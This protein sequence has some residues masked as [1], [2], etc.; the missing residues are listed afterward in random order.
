VMAIGGVAA[1]AYAFT[2]DTVGWQI[3]IFAVVS[4]GGTVLARPTLIRMFESKT[5]TPLLPGVQQLVGQTAIATGDV[6]D[7]HHAGHVRIGGESWLAVCDGDAAI[8]AETEVVI[9]AVRGT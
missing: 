9:I 4:L 7:E 8:A 5:P 2:S 3:A 1:M 6:G